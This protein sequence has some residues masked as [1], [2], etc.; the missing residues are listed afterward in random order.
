MNNLHESKAGDLK[1]ALALGLI[2]KVLADSPGATGVAKMYHTIK[3][4]YEKGCKMIDVLCGLT[5][6]PTKPGGK[7][8]K[9]SGEKD[10]DTDKK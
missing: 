3:P 9:A 8:T 1:A 4:D 10:G 5:K 2:N 6:E 7:S